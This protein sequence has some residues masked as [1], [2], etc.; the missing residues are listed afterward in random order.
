ML[1]DGITQRAV[2]GSW[3]FHSDHNAPH[4]LATEEA[5]RETWLWLARLSCDS[6]LR[7]THLRLDEDNRTVNLCCVAGGP[8]LLYYAATPI[9]TTHDIAIG[10]VF[11]VDR[12]DRSSWLQTDV[13]FLEQT[14]KKCMAQLESSRA[15]HLRGRVAKVGDARKSFIY[16]RSI[17]AQLNEEPPNFRPASGYQDMR[18][19]ENDVRPNE[20]LDEA[21]KSIVRSELQDE[22]TGGDE[23]RM[24]GQAGRPSDNPQGETTYRKAF[25]KAAEVLRTG[26]D[27]D[28]VVFVDGIVGFHGGLTIAPQQESELET[29]LF[30]RPGQRTESSV[31]T[32][33]QGGYSKPAEASD[34]PTQ[35]TGG[36]RS[37]SSADYEKSVLLGSPAECLGISFID[38][39]R[40]RLAGISP[41]TVGL[42][43]IDEGF[44]QQVLAKYPDGKLW[45]FDGPNGTPYGFSPDDRL[46]K[47][48]EESCAHRISSSFPG[49]R[50]LFF[51][52]LTDPSSMKRLAG[53]FGWTT[54]VH[55]TFTEALDLNTMANYLCLVESEISR[56]DTTAAIKQQE[57]FVSSVSHELRTP[58]HGILGAVE[59]L[60]ETKL[61]DFQQGLTE[62][63]RSCGST[64][65]DTLSSVLSYAKINQFERRRNKPAQRGTKESPWAMENKDA[66]REPQGI[67][68]LFCSCNIATLCEEVIEVTAGGNMYSKL[69]TGATD[70]LEIILDIGYWDD[71]N[72]LTE[73]GALRRIMTNILGNALKYTDCGFIK[74]SL[75]VQETQKK[76]THLGVPI[77]NL[78]LLKFTVEDTG[79]GMSKDFVQRHLFVP[80]T[81]EDTVGSEGVGLGMSIVKDLVSLLGGKIDVKSKLDVGSTFTV[82][83]PMGEEKNPAPTSGPATALTEA[84]REICQKPRTVAI[85]G[86]DNLL[87]QSLTEYFQNWFQWEVVDMEHDQNPPPVVL[88]VNYANVTATKKACEHLEPGSF[89]LLNVL[90]TPP[91]ERIAEHGAEASTKHLTVTLPIGPAKLSKAVLKCIARLTQTNKEEDLGTGEMKE[92][93]DVSASANR[94]DS[95]S[96]NEPKSHSAARSLPASTQPETSPK[97]PPR[98]DKAAPPQA[99]PDERTPWLLLV[100]DNAINLKLLNTFM[101]K[102]GC[103]NVRT[104]GNGHLAVEE[105]TKLNDQSL[106]FDIIFMGEYRPLPTN[107]H[108]SHLHPFASAS[109]KPIQR[110]QLTQSPKPQTSACP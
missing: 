99:P 13:D 78:K 17:A 80:F 106:G 22:P 90:M 5:D 46:V 109:S 60:A 8:N 31:R 94:L 45:Y 96:L 20:E 54:R 30:Q 56:I 57:S 72:F 101:T 89:V 19:C 41:T 39:K 36:T 21:A 55:P 70:G 77:D 35:D 24:S 38:G 9:R 65:H 110:N 84:V 76:S 64:L 37:F 7:T 51:A 108:L 10:T 61:D 48:D 14:A 103:K 32:Q 69:A 83:I 4:W 34:S 6:P 2:A 97:A 29:E 88:V 11:L 87:L 93:D 73:P 12:R 105:V 75:H 104:A 85:C 42:E 95:M 1:T 47:E 67:D 18:G 82:S 16:S 68:G 102:R 3:G 100:D 26:F 91:Q 62:S 25:R 63:I 15:A 58:L 79:K 28:G 66:A 86:F 81:Q 107:T 27:L 98:S 23:S 71:W 40:P 50:Q 53:C 44:L 49:V 43:R 59:F 52:P 92:Q 33:K 74:V